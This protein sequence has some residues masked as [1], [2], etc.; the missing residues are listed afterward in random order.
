MRL[1]DLAGNG[2]INYSEFLTCAL[3]EQLLKCDLVR[4][5]AFKMLDTLNEGY[6]THQ[7]IKIAMRR[8]K[9]GVSDE[10]VEAMLAE[11]CLGAR[12]DFD[13]FNS[14]FDN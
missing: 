6:L 3:D 7:G 1:A 8:Y 12:L 9:R 5:A 13:Q 14:I 4:L 11:A 10:E 2:K